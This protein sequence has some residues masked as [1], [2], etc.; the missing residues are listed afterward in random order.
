MPVI[1]DGGTVVFP[2]SLGQ[3]SCHNPGIPLPSD[4]Y[5][6]FKKTLPGVS[7]KSDIQAWFKSF[8]ICYLCVES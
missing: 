2:G 1:E 8:R 4:A 5:T 3:D 7:A 6:L